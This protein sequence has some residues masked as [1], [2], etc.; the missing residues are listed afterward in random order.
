MINRMSYKVRD[1]QKQRILKQ[2]LLW[3]LMK[4]RVI[5]GMY[6]LSVIDNYKWVINHFQ[7]IKYLRMGR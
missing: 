6:H 7:G 3:E 1:G 5:D 2:W 4:K